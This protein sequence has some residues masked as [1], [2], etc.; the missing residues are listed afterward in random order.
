MPFEASTLQYLEDAL[1]GCFNYH[2]SLDNLL[3]RSGVAAGELAAARTAAEEMA[4]AS[5]TDF[6]RAPKRF[7][8]QSLITALS[9][10]EKDGDYALSN[11]LTA[12]QKGSFPEAGNDAL[13]AI[14]KLRKQTEDDQQQKKK[15]EE[16]KQAE[17]RQREAVAARTAEAKFAKKQT[18]R[19]E[20]RE[21]FVALMREEDAQARG[22][23]FE[24]FLGDMFVAE[25]M[26]PQSPFKNEGEQIDG[27]FSWRNQTHLVEAKWTQTPS[28]SAEFSAFMFKIEGKTADTRGL[29]VS[30]NGYSETALKGL[31]S[32]GPLKFVCVDGVH[33]MR[34]L[35]VGQSL[36]SIL[37]IIWRHAD[38]TGE[39][40]LPVDR[41]P[42]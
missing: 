25:E 14:E 41:F 37:E 40:Y 11:L 12:V 36:S 7:V 22:Y 34:S 39:A 2:N 1:S 26:F 3:L 33:I 29:F 17:R 16:A 42:K 6:S 38:Q 23:L 24:E 27:S 21:R 19:D 18:K 10:Q 4:N 5:P 31:M 15:E 35:E 9:A 13:V 32:K 8:V 30:V 20:L 28:A